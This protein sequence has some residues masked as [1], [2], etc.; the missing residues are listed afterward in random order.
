MVSPT[1]SF[2]RTVQY[3]ILHVTSDSLTVQKTHQNKLNY[4]PI[5]T[6]F[7]NSIFGAFG[8]V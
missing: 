1:W 4:L 3:K 8:V 6:F 5:F 7:L 2:M